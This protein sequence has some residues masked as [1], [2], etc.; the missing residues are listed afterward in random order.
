MDIFIEHIVQRKKTPQDT[1]VTVGIMIAVLLIAMFALA[2]PFGPIIVVAVGYGAYWLI[3]SRNIEFE[4]S[5][6]NGEL[7]VDKIIA[8]RRRKRILSIH[9]KEFDIVAPV[10]DEKYKRE[11]TNVN[12]KKS[13]D[14]MSSMNAENLYFAV[15]TLDGQK[16]RLIF[17]PTGKMLEAFKTY[18][19]RKV[20][21]R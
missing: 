19:P 4:Y 7:D 1:L 15:F 3:T 14:A 12:I 13:I 5:V 20:F 9:C 18:I 10:H 16:A 21:T 17:E 11:F 6:T 8:Q 2:L